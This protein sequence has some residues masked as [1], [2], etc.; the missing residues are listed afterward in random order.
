MT[1]ITLARQGSDLAGVISM[2]GALAT[3]RRAEPGAVRAKVLACHGAQDPHV[4]VADVTAFMEEMTNAGADWQLIAYGNAVHGFTHA[5]AVPGA[6]PGVE[7]DQATDRRSFEA[8]RQFLA[9]LFPGSVAP[10]D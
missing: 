2:H 9:E 3:P 1:V 10:A 4:P 5:D 6:I 7:Y 8:A